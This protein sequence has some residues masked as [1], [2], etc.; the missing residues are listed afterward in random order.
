MCLAHSENGAISTAGETE[1]KSDVRGGPA[2]TSQLKTASLNIL[3]PIQDAKEGYCAMKI[4]GKEETTLR[5]AGNLL[6]SSSEIRGGKFERSKPQNHG[7]KTTITSVLFFLHNLR[8]KKQN[9][10]DF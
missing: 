3:L 7:N 10:T 4:V 6:R 9:V 1:G 8:R 2:A 5:I